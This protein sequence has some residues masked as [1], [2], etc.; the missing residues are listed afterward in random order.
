MLNRLTRLPCTSKSSEIMLPDMSS[1][2][3]ISTPLAVT[4]VSL[5]VSRGWASATMNSASASQRSAA[6]KP[7][8]RVRVMLRM[9]RTS[10][11]EE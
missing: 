8:A 7:P 9:P 6:R 4:L 10:W 1:A 3:T 11:T 2:T 5:W